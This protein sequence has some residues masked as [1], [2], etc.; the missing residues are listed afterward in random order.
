MTI[1]NFW[2]VRCNRCNTNLSDNDGKDYWIRHFKTFEE[3][4][5]AA[6]ASGWGELSE[7]I[8]CS[9]CIKPQSAWMVAGNIRVN[10]HRTDN[11]SLNEVVTNSLKCDLLN[12]DDEIIHQ[13]AEVIC[14]KITEEDTVT[15]NDIKAL[16]REHGINR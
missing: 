2:L 6:I 16:Y 9:V 12:V 8:Y 11:V 3:A 14:I 5:A 1:A 10:L 7:G 15:E 13:M 4:R